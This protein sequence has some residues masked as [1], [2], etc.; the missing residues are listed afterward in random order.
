MYVSTEVTTPPQLLGHFR[1]ILLHGVEIRLHRSPPVHLGIGLPTIAEWFAA[2]IV[3]LKVTSVTAIVTRTGVVG[4][5]PRCLFGAVSFRQCRLKGVLH[6]IHERG[7][8][9]PNS[10]AL[11]QSTATALFTG[12]T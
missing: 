9:R 11:G 12:T 4:T 10:R 3:N 7:V 8:A 2:G 5:F 6:N 1:P